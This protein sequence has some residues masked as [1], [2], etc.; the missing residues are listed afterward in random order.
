MIIT[1]TTDHTEK[2]L[3]DYSTALQ[4]FYGSKYI[5]YYKAHPETPI[6]G[7]EKKIN[8]LKAINVIPMDS[9]I[10][11]EVIS[12]FMKDI[13]HSGYYSSTFIE[14]DE[15]LLRNMFN[16]KK[17]EGDLYDKF[18]FF[19]SY[20]KKNDKTYGKCLGDNS[21]GILLEFNKKKL[22]NM[23]YNLGIYLKMENKINY[24]VNV[25]CD[26]GCGDKISIQYFSMF[27]ILVFSIIVYL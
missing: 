9:N 14:L 16:H 5:Y 13:N 20:I 22:V 11:L 21:D 7:N 27:L 19:S 10:P 26:S 2:N 18:D 1:G 17:E 12:F 15:D 23:S 25:I 8:K 3:I 4:C 24:Y 6:E